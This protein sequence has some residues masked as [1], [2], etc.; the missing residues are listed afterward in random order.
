MGKETESKN[1][2]KIQENTQFGEVQI[3]NN[4][5]AIIAALSATEVEGVVGMSGNI[6]NE[7]ISKLGVK[8]LSSGVKVEV[9][10]GLVKVALS[11]ELEYGVSLP[12]VCAAVQ[13]KV[14]SSI[15][16]MTGLSVG[17]VNVRIVG[18]A[19]DKE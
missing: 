2:Y 7:I 11:L 8:N 6:T 16:L 10:E 13:D 3:A 12:E 5:I 14:K 15:E 17:E 4:V 9:E 19:L 18:I 1:T